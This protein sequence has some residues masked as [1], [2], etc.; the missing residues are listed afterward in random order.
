MEEEDL[1]CMNDLLPTYRNSHSVTDLFLI[2]SH[3][4]RKIRYCQSLTHYNVRSDQVSVIMDLDDG[5]DKE[6]EV[7]KEKY[8]IRKADWQKWEEVSE[9]KFSEWN[10]VNHETKSTDQM[11]ESFTEL[12]HESMD[13]TVPKVMVKK[14]S[15][16]RMAP[17]TYEEVKNSKHELNVTKK[18]F[19]RRQTPDILHSLRENEE[20]YEKVCDKAKSE[21]TENICM[22][23]N[24]C[25]NPKEIWQ[26]V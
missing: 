16:R 24:D 23:K 25:N 5:I 11:V 10:M 18:K 14:G 17:W 19:W 9:E 15:R 21:W 4:N 20:K 8:S 1:V 22:K 2:R 7:V 6:K 26:K 12:F 3:M 13:K